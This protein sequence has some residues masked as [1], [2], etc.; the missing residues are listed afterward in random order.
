MT[1]TPRGYVQFLIINY[2]TIKAN[3]TDT[4]RRVINFLGLDV[5]SIQG[6]TSLLTRSSRCLP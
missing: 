3:E 4:L 5:D 6:V 2:D 1:R